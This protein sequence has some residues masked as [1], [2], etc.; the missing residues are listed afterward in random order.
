MS[1]GYIYFEYKEKNF[2]WELAKIS[3]KNIMNVCVSFFSQ[4]NIIK[5]FL[6]LIPLN[7]YYI[8]LNNFKPYKSQILNKLDSKIMV[9]K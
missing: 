7:I 2:Y 1:F 5:G 9:K 6:I 3:L 4:Y 8:A